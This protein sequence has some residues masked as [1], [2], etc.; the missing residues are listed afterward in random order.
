MERRKEKKGKRKE[1]IEELERFLIDFCI[2]D[3]VD[4]ELL[5]FKKKGNK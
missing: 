1:N 4:E 3:E 5:K 2:R